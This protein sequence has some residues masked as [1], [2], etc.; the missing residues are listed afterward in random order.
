MRLLISNKSAA[1]AF[2]WTRNAPVQLC[3]RTI[4]KIDISY[5]TVVSSLGLNRSDRGYCRLVF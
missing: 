2:S 4:I 5:E 1:V 3:E